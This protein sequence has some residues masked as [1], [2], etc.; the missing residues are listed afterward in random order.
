M[1]FRL[2]V[3]VALWLLAGHAVA[4]ANDR[5]PTEEERAK[6][7]AAMQ[8]EGCSG[9]AMEVDDDSYEVDNARCS[10]GRTYDLEFDKSFKLIVKDLED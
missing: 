1:R 6:V 9:G 3:S 2:L 5:P 8:A 4:Q 10:D 7:S